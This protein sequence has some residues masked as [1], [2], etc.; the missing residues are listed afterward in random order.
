[1][2]PISFTLGG[3]STSF[4]VPVFSRAVI[5]FCMACFQQVNLLASTYVVGSVREAMDKG[6]AQW[7]GERLVYEM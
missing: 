7:E 4:Q 2:H 5:S 6:K 1:M 3:K